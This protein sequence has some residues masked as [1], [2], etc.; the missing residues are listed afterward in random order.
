MS[1]SEYVFVFGSNLAGR[2]GR[3]AALDAVQ[4]H[5]AVYGQGVGRQGMAYAVPTKD[6]DLRTLP[7]TVIADYAKAFVDYA[8]A[9]PQEQFLLTRVGCGLA[10]YTDEQMAPLFGPVPSNVTYPP[11]WERW[12]GREEE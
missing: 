3:G 10:G 12:C 4:H 6:H 1:A 7:L 5:G 8:R 2:H 9:H 11:E